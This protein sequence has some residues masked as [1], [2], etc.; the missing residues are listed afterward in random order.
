MGE[1]VI[2]LKEQLGNAVLDRNGKVIPF[3]ALGGDYG[4]IKLDSDR[5]KDMI[6]DIETAIKEH[7]GGIYK[8]NDAEYEK[9]KEIPRWQP[10]VS[11]SDQQLRVFSPP[12][13]RPAVPVA[14]AAEGKPSAQPAASGVRPAPIPFGDLVAQQLTQPVAKEAGSSGVVQAPVD[15]EKSAAP[16]PRM[17]RASQAKKNPIQ[18]QPTA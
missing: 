3:H 16:K 17:G 18:P 9:K 13:Q 4:G 1:Q 7:R 2:Y 6:A 8:S 10:S 12:R 14:P 11:Q 5:D 15:A